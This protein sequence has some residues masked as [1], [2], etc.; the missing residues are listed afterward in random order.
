MPASSSKKSRTFHL[1]VENFR[2]RQSLFHLT[3]PI[4]AA[5]AKRHRALARHLT[6]TIGWDGDILDEALKTADFLINS[7]PP[8]ERLRARAPNLQWIQTTGAG[9]DGLLPFDWLPA[10]ITLTNNSGAHGDKAEDY[11]AMALLMLQT[12]A[13][14]MLANQRNKKWE[15]IF[16][17]PI[18]GKTAVV[19]G[20]GDLGSAAGRAAHKLGLKVIAVTRSG[21]AGRPADTAC[22]V[23]RIDSVL[24]KADFVIVT[25]PLTPDTHGLLNRARLDLMKP[26]AGLI[27][28]GRSPIVDYAALREKLDNGELGGAI[29]DVHS[30]EPLPADSPLW[31]TRNLIVTPHISCDDPRYM[32]FL[33]DTWF[34]NFARKL[35]G[36]PLKHQVDRELGY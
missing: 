10:D 31:T 17:E 29:L 3:E 22:K 2:Q 32:D 33:C 11:C 18:A 4:Y 35:A 30:P 19:I 7:S 28:I 24:P 13:P 12:R 36:K 26:T 9:I 27:N 16:T 1:H 21:S 25:T 8:K 34:A 5:A 23:S 20:F 6:V 14:A 15:P